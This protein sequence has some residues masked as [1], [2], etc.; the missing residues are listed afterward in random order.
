MKNKKREKLIILSPTGE[1]IGVW[2][3][4]P[5]KNGLVYGIPKDN[6]HITV[7]SK[8]GEISAHITPQEHPEDRRY[9]PPMT[10]ERLVKSVK[11]A[12]EQGLF[13]KLSAS[14]LSEEVFYVSQRFVDWFNS[15][16]KALVREETSEEE[17]IHILDVGS[18]IEKLPE[19]VEELKGFPSSFFGSCKAREILEDNSKA[20]GMIVE[21][22]NLKTFLYPLENELYAIDYQLI[23]GFN[24]EPEQDMSNPVAEL[25]RSLGISRYI[26]DIKKR[27]LR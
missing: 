18:F 1:E 16:M 2:F 3:M 24:L 8:K 6:S 11:S 5:C 17:V 21:N 4:S 25:A 12:I 19:F 23:A 15:L 27:K 9:F 20:L 13:Y 22:D 10:I 26:E 14:Q 7:V